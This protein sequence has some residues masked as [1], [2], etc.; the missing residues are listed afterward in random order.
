[1]DNLGFNVSGD[2]VGI[3]I[4]GVRCDLNSSGYA[5]ETDLTILGI[6]QISPLKKH[7]RQYPEYHCDRSKHCAV[8]PLHPVDQWVT[9]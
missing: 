9:I 2:S 6:S 5:L 7:D 8:A 4:V 3:E 1:M